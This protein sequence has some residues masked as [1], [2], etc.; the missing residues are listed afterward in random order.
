LS[1]QDLEK[2]VK[3]LKN[4]HRIGG[5]PNDIVKVLAQIKDCPNL[6][7]KVTVLRSTIERSEKA[8]EVVEQKL[9]WRKRLLD[10]CKEVEELQISLE[11]LRTLKNIVLESAAANSLQPEN[12]FR[13][14]A[15]DVLT[16]Y[17]VLLCLDKKI[18][19]INQ[20]LSEI[21]VS[22]FNKIKMVKIPK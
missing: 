5:E 3:V 21:Q 15:V 16:N 8:L 14:I 17:D 2:L 4:V 11:D 6:E 10:K 19:E 20:K 12:A 1:F 22:R 7:E 18:R 9:A 13:S